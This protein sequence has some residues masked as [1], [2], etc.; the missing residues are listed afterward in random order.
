MSSRVVRDELWTSERVNAL[1]DR[2]FRLYMALVSAADDYGLVSI[3][4]GEIRR[5]APLLTWGREEVAKMLGELVDSTLISPYE[6]AGK[7]YAAVQ[8]WQSYVRTVKPRYAIPSFGMG[9]CRMPYGFKSVKVRNAAALYLKHLDIERVAPGLP[10]GVPGD[11]L[12]TV[13][14]EGVREL[15]SE[16]VGEKEETTTTQ[17]AVAPATTKPKASIGAC[18]YQEVIALWA[19]V[20]PELPQVRVLS[21]RVEAN[22]RQRWRERWVKKGWK[23]Q[24]DGLSWFRNFF[25]F[26]RDS[27][28][29][30]G[31]VP[32]VPPRTT[33]FEFTLKYAMNEDNFA[34]ILNHEFHRE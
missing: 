34:R 14:S 26:C 23:S 10:Q 24:A 30:M 21:S 3:A 13:G 32:P 18:P 31:K 9:H 25:T 5:A 7:P 20:M 33:P 19:E 6:D 12:G 16:G 27:R 8:N 2:T 17:V 22:M 1:H 28:W 11:D 4:Y 15:E 29:L